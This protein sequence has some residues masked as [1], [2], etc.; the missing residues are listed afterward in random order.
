MKQDAYPAA[1]VDCEEGEEFECVDEELEAAELEAL[2][3]YDTAFYGIEGH[4]E[5]LLPHEVWEEDA[6]QVVQE[7]TACHVAYKAKGKSRGGKRRGKKGGFAIR[8]GWLTL[9]ERKKKLLKLKLR[10]K[11]KKCGKPGHWAGDPQCKKPKGQ[12]K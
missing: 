12:G 2:E 5:I 8:K 10:T 3:A 9:E 1:T 7:E 4:E 11:C 6:A